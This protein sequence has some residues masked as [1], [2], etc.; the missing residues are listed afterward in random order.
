MQ[1]QKLVDILALAMSGRVNVVHPST[2]EVS[3]K[4]VRLVEFE[5]CKIQHVLAALSRGFAL[6]LSLFLFG[7]RI[8]CLM[9]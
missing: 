9:M 5:G 6:A 3:R 2:R 7:I 8:F 4:V 1:Y